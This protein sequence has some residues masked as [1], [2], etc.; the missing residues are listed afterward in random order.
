MSLQVLIIDDDPAFVMMHKRRVTTSSIATS[1]QAYFNGKA[2][3]E[4][5]S[6]PP[7]TDDHYLLL[8]DINMPVMDGWGLLNAIQQ[9]PNANKIYAVMISSSLDKKDREKAWEYPQ[10]IGFYEKAI[11]IDICNEIKQNPVIAHFYA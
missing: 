3:F 7:N 1:P 11:S 5:I 2:A 10:V 9:M 6:N 8:L 4:A